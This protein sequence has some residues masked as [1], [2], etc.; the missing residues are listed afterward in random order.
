MKLI[1]SFFALFAVATGSA[2]LRKTNGNDAPAKKFENA[3][4]YNDYIINEQ[5]RVGMVIK[6]FNAAFERSKDT[7]E[8]HTARKA[9]IRQADSAITRIKNLVPFKGDTSLKKNALRLFRFYSEIAGKEYR[10]FVQLY[11]SKEKITTEI[12]KQL[13]DIVADITEREKVLDA[14]FQEAQK[15][16]AAKYNIKLTENEFKIDQ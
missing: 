6:E 8:I 14:N 2:Q 4:D 9:I 10:E 11:F 15:A 12:S 7:L 16:F 3:V 1:L 5:T 13:Q